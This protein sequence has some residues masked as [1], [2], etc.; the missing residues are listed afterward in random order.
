MEEDKLR[1]G[2]LGAAGPQEGAYAW[3]AGNSEDTESPHRLQAFRVA[4]QC[5]LELP[6]ARLIAGLAYGEGSANG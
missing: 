2:A 3:S 6:S 1:P 4:R 5:G